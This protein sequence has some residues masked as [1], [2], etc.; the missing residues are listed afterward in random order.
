[1]LPPALTLYTSRDALPCSA[2][3]STVP[4]CELYRVSAFTVQALEGNPAAVVLDA[5]AL[6]A[7]AMQAI[8][9]ELKLSETAFVLRSERADARVRYFTPIEEMPL[10]GHPTL[11]TVHVLRESGRIAR[12]AEQVTLEMP[13]GIIPVHIAPDAHGVRYT[14]R[15]PAPTFARVY[16]PERVAGSLHLAADDVLASPAPQTVSTGAPM[17]MVALRS[18]RALDAATRDPAEL[19]PAD[20]DYMS[21]HL[22]TRTNEPHAFLARHFSP[23][24]D[25]PEDPVTGSACGAMAA[26]AY[27]YGLVD[28]PAFTVLQGTHVHRPGIVYA[29]VLGTPYAMNG[30]E[31]GGYAVTTGRGTT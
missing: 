13:A 22:F 9:R 6:A 25:V 15:Q 24:G 30:V 29:R 4:A 2:K 26:Y 11:A 10:A 12:E 28:R 18:V 19:F 14:M 23:P 16:D 20:R 27:R 1:M 5:D 8:A 7:T 31:I 3:R 21:V 17:L